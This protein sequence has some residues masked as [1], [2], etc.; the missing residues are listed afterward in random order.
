[1]GEFQKYVAELV[2]DQSDGKLVRVTALFDSAKAQPLLEILKFRYEAPTHQDFE[3]DRNRVPLNL[4]GIY[5]P[6]LGA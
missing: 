4:Y 1:M 2:A 5:S 6:P 3:V